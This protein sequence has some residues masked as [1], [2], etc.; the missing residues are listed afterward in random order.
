MQKDDNAVL[1]GTGVLLGVIAG[2]IGAVLY[3][4]KPGEE[5]RK[6]FEKVVTDAAQ[7]Y[8]PEIT[9][10]KKQALNSIEVMRFRLEERYN[11]LAEAI[12]AKQIAKAKEKE[13]I[14]YE[15]N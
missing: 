2:V 11:K 3:A 12:R 8:A 15:V 14:D 4:P 6:D 1:F 13:T 9:E 10:A 7:K 5:T